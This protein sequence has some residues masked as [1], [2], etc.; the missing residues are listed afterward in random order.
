MYEK[1]K[2]DGRRT[3]CWRKNIQFY[4]IGIVYNCNNAV[5]NV[6]ILHVCSI[7]DEI[8]KF[9]MS[10]IKTNCNNFY[11][12][13][14]LNSN[15]YCVSGSAIYG[16]EWRKNSA[17]YNTVIFV[18]SLTFSS[19]FLH[20]RLRPC[21]SWHSF[22]TLCGIYNLSLNIYLYYTHMYIFYLINILWRYVSYL[23]FDFY[24]IIWFINKHYLL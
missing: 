22:F 13:Y 12:N 8:K 17:S 1:G 2:Q 14:I 7:S 3:R 18:P 24:L 5:N 6:Q 10:S 19:F 20:S 21:F 11:Y 9:Y 16:H 15:F 4:T 23:T